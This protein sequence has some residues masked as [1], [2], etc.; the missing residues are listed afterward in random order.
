MI[1]NKE[2]A[3]YELKSRLESMGF[4][5]VK[6]LRGNDLITGWKN[7]PGSIKKITV[8]GVDGFSAA[9]TFD[10]DAEIVIVV[11]TFKR[12]GCEDITDAA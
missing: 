12:K 4:Q 2:E 7:P 1:N 10:Y 8:N 3:Y 5:N 11:H 9:D 6:L